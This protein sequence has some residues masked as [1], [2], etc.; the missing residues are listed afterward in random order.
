L[1]FSAAAGRRPSVWK[2][3]PEKRSGNKI[4]SWKKALNE[5]EKGENGNG[6]GNGKKRMRE[7]TKKGR[8]AGFI[9]EKTFPEKESGTRILYFNPF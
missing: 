3:R 6:N 4:K 8:K 2:K 7:K 9:L 1:F 5:K